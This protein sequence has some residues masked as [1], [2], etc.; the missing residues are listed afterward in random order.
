MV[1]TPR[2]KPLL[3]PLMS[4]FD[5]LGCHVLFALKSHQWILPITPTKIPLNNLYGPCQLIWLR[6][7]GKLADP[8]SGKVDILKPGSI[9]NT[10]M[11]ANRMQLHL[12]LPKRNHSKSPIGL[13]LEF[14]GSLST[15]YIRYL[16]QRFGSNLYFPTRSVVIQSAI[17]LAKAA[18]AQ[19][20]PEELSK[21]IFDWLSRLHLNSERNQLHLHA[22]L[23]GDT[24]CL[25]DIF[26]NHGHSIKSL[27]EYFGCSSV[28]LSQQLRKMWNKPTT[29]VLKYIRQQ[30]AWKLLMEETLT[31]DEI[32][33]RCGFAN[34][35]SF[36]TTFKKETGYRPSQA[37]AIGYKK[38]LASPAPHKKV[39]MATLSSVDH[40]HLLQGKHAPVAVWGDAYF[41][42]DGGISEVLY[43]SPFELSFNTVTSAMFW[44]VTLE[45]EALF[46]T[47]NTTLQVRP[48]TVVVYPQPMN[49][50]WAT[51]KLNGQRHWR[52]LWLNC[53]CNWGNNALM[54]LGAAHDWA[55][56]V[57]L[58]SKPV[59][60]A[61]KW[62]EHWHAN[63]HFPS[64]ISSRAA[65]EWLQSWWQLLRSGQVKALNSDQGTAMPDLCQ[66]MSKSFYRQIKTITKFSEQL[67][68]S[69]RHTT[70]KLN[71]QWDSGTPAQVVRN[72][73]LAQAALE[74]RHTRLPVS[75]IARKAQY[76]SAGS[77]IPAFKRVFKISPLAYRRTQT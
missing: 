15:D 5:F 52:R 31:I 38:T 8:I 41:Q 60:F 12:E 36:A 18:S 46:E 54:A 59:L 10:D 42:F 67:G 69:R 75:E 24:S 39:K 76:A 72:Q 21:Y 19:G 62:V 23:S 25:T 65:F 9:W 33:K 32:A 70:R 1:S 51:P 30:Y 13:L 73:R 34:S 74:L 48:G 17:K 77:F 63:R 66:Y 43:E 14:S 26:E 44:V 45:G 53:R 50:R 2:E 49:G 16:V 4:P 3:K 29:R 22:L 7:R 40:E 57:P 20:S 28:W 27:S 58:E 56:T 55:A 6:G 35:S 68:Y 64:V 11:P 37:R 47:G 71:M 61:Q